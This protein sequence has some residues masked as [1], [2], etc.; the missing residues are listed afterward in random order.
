MNNS[1]KKIQAWH[2]RRQQRNKQRTLER[3]KKIRARGKTW[4]VFSGALSYV[5]AMGGILDVIDNVFY[6]GTKY[7]L[8]S[9]TIGY[10]IMAMVLAP[11]T[12]WDMEGRY[13]AAL[14][15]GRVKASPHSKSHP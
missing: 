9:N 15:D 6:G 10:S 5:L 8:L 11:V 12:W 7:S 3:W 1:L 2:S 13:K 14:I 4:F